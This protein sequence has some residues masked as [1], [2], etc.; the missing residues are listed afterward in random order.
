MHDSAMSCVFRF[1]ALHG[2]CTAATHLLPQLIHAR[3]QAARAHASRLHVGRARVE[4][5]AQRGQ[6]DYNQLARRVDHGQAAAQARLQ[7]VGPFAD[8]P[9]APPARA[10]LF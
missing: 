5:Q 10:A 4:R 8:G 7:Q 1:G 9:P 6:R 3:T 2:V